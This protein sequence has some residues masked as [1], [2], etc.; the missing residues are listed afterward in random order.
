MTTPTRE[1]CP[2]C[3]S[4]RDELGRLQ[5]GFCHPT[6]CLMAK[7]RAKRRL[8]CALAGARTPDEVDRVLRRQF[9]EEEQ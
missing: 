5:I 4:R 7:E 8:V 3:W 1:D 9:E 2:T 6:E